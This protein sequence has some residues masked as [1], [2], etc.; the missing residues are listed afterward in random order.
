MARQ[1]QYP[2]LVPPPDPAAE[3]RAAELA[4][5]WGAIP[6][7]NPAAE[8]QAQS[9]GY[10]P[11]PGP[12]PEQA[13]LAGPAQG[14]YTPESAEDYV[15][16]GMSPP[17]EL[18]PP[19]DTVMAG[20]QYPVKTAAENT[21][22]VSQE[23]AVNSPQIMVSR[24]SPGRM[25]LAG[26]TEQ[27]KGGIDVPD[28][29][30]ELRRGAHQTFEGSAYDAYKAAVDSAKIKRAEE[31]GVSQAEQDA[32]AERAAVMRRQ[33]NEAWAVR[34]KYENMEIDPRRVWNN[35]NAFQ[36]ITAT[37]GMALGGMLHAS[38]GS[39]PFIDMMNT[40]IDRDIAAQRANRDAV[41]DSFAMMGVEH[42][43][44]FGS[45]EEE[46]IKRLTAVKQELIGMDEQL[47]PQESAARSNLQGILAEVDTQLSDQILEIAKL[48][49]EEKMRSENYKIMGASPPRFA[50]N[51]NYVVGA[52]KEVKD[53]VAQ[54]ANIPEDK[55]YETALG[56]FASLI[57]KPPQE[58][59]AW[60]HRAENIDLISGGTAG[61]MVAFDAD[62]Y[63]GVRG[64]EHDPRKQLE[65]AERSILLG[66]DGNRRT[67]LVLPHSNAIALK[68]QAARYQNM[69]TM[70]KLLER[71]I[72]SGVTTGT[73]PTTEAR[74]RAQVLIPLLNSL[75]KKEFGDEW[76]SPFGSADS[77]LT[78]EG[79]LRAR[80]LSELIEQIHMD[81]LEIQGGQVYEVTQGADA[82][83]RRRE[84]WERKVNTA[85][86]PVRTP[87]L[88]TD[89]DKSPAG[90]QGGGAPVRTPSLD[91]YTG[92]PSG[93][94]WAEIGLRRDEE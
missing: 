3:A 38:T 72:V 70:A 64:T 67:V 44:E 41:K 4:G 32:A 73:A 9:W 92:V 63:T 50:V 40:V 53:R 58:A 55:Q 62:S 69:A 42:E 77:L 1:P 83:N 11:T 33:E 51:P 86:L 5:Q 74:G 13:K 36:Q 43:K 91:P 78:T 46:K 16:R 85:N 12:L 10:G 35:M 68:E 31:L 27:K 17:S 7:A 80:V 54:N 89:A 93:S 20:G 47:G 65:M 48:E 45:V 18:A 59:A 8:A 57:N 84:H 60:A 26:Y 52:W 90:A 23:A 15:A 75:G 56:I 94:S 6:Q 34:N 22:M 49:S 21:R 71:M 82:M 28:E 37:I 66:A 14:G 29:V 39:N 61:G 19:A 2:W 30:M 79:A 87:R 24:G 88:P 76:E 25:G 81:R